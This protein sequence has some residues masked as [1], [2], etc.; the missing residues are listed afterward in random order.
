MPRQPCYAAPIVSGLQ[1]ARTQRKSIR[2]L[3]TLSPEL[4]ERVEKFRETFGASSESD[5]L[6]V[7]IEDGLKMRDR[8]D[9]LFERLKNAT[10]NGQSLGD[11]IN[12]L[13]ADH[14]LVLS[15]LLT[16]DQLEI[17]LRTSTDEPDQQFSFSRLHRKWD[18][19]RRVGSNFDD[20]WE[21]VQPPQQPRERKPINDLDD[22]IPF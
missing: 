16:A 7:L 12:L 6:K 9:D 18:W 8:R 13:A 22:D 4:A 14:P 10:Q 17:N 19:L 5:A 3:V 11:I 1:M 15:T 21:S 20:Q 2:K